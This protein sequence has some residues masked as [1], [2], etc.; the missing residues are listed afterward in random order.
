[1]GEK[2]IA[3]NRKARYNYEIID[4][5]EAGV[6]LLGTEVK[7]LRDGRVNFKDSHARLLNGEV[8]LHGL[9]ISPYSHGSYSNHEP[10][11]KRKLLLHRAEI[12]K[13]IG[14]I[15]ESGLTLIP[16]KL[17]FKNGKVKAEI[18]LARGKRTHDKRQTIAKRE[19]DREI[20]RRLK[21]R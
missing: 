1:M 2:V 12:R 11:R 15:Q 3:A 16:L 18:A 6:A 4:R 7:S 20:H 19:A 14:K 9:H 8:W 13:L 10:E 21:L 5:Y 17:Y